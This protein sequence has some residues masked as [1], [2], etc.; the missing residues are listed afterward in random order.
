[1]HKRTHL[2]LNKIT[3]KVSLSLIGTYYFMFMIGKIFH[4]FKIFYFKGF[5]GI[6]PF[7]ATPLKKRFFVFS[8]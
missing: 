5:S 1:M 8:Q 3:K 7:V 6:V 2:L 4:C